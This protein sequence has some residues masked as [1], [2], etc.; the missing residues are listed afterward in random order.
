[1]ALLVWVSI[2][3]QA[4]SKTPRAAA[5]QRGGSCILDMVVIALHQWDLAAI[6]AGDLLQLTTAR[7]GALQTVSGTRANDFNSI[8]QI[9][10]LFLDRKNQL[11]ADEVSNRFRHHTSTG[12]E[13]SL[14]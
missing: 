7:G 4:R 5:R 3:L 8:P 9:R 1:M 12:S 11:I 13:T 6:S 2:S 10:I 14:S